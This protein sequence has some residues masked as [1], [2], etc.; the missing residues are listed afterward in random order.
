MNDRYRCV[1]LMAVVGA[2]LL[3]GVTADG[4]G[5][6]VEWAG[7]GEH[8]FFLR[9]EPREIGPRTYDEMPAQ[10]EIDF[11]ALLRGITGRIDPASLQVIRFDARTGK[12]IRSNNAFSTGPYDQPF[13]WY[14][15]AIPYDFPEFAQALD[16]T[17]GTIE[18]QVIER[19]GYYYGAVGN[20]ERGRLA[21]THT[22]EG[23]RSSDYAVYFSLLPE[24]KAPGQL[25][26]RGWLGD[27][28]QRTEPYGS[29]TTGAG[30][31]RIAVA[32]W[33]ND[34]LTDILYGEDYGHLFWMPNT[35]RRD[36]PE[37]SHSRMITDGSDVPV[38]AGV[39]LAPLIVDWNGDGLKD[40]LA[41]THW[42]RVAF[43]KNVGTLEHPRLVYRGLLKADNAIFTLPFRPI[44]GRSPDPFKTDY[45]PVLEAA[46]W[47]GDGQV[48][49]LA[50]GYVTGR[51]F[52]FR[53]VGR[54]SD[55]LPSLEFQGPLEA[56][57]APLNVGD[58]CAAPTAADFDGDGDLDLMS[59]SLAMTIGEDLVDRRKRNFLRYYENVGT[60][61][62]AILKEVDFPRQG[63]FPSGGLATPRAVDLNGDGL[64]DLA[65]SSRSDIYIYSNIGSS[66]QPRFAVH[67]RPLRVRWGRADLPGTG[68]ETPTQFL[69][70]NADGH[71]DIVSA[72]QVWINDG[73]GSPGTYRAPVFVVPP[74]QRI[75]HTSGTGDGWFW[76]RL[77][78][79]DK[80][81][82]F[83]VLFG[84]FS[85]RIWFHRNRG[86]A[87][88]PQIDTQ[89]Y[90][91]Q[92]V[93]GQEIRVGPAGLDPTKSFYALQGARTVFAMADMDQDG[94]NDIVVGDTFGTV[95]YYENVGSS[96][97]PV[98]A[99]AHPVGDL[100]S[101]LLVDAADW[102]GDGKID[103]LAGSSSGEVRVFLNVGKTD[104]ARFAEGFDPKL[105]RIIQ[106]RVMAVDL[107]DDGDLDVFLPSTQGSCFVERSFVEHGYAPGTLLG[108][109][110]T[111]RLTQRGDR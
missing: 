79:L 39:G 17:K 4:A 40:L 62:K 86:T 89:G 67:D 58:W 37:F 36:R 100:K 96:E 41:G 107:N 70:W 8:R 105:P 80:D 91:L 29:T 71:L 102:N 108:S 35:G 99:A 73:Q 52:F 77:Y 55:G 47:D 76:P 23:N 5:P 56:D 1:G 12:P 109:L 10:V 2:L 14:D 3:T 25:A 85:G 50:G 53:N 32:D 97:K 110:E 69:D 42:N 26:P 63:E 83:D 9:V 87:E 28:M 19:A 15:A 13:R 60:R 51:I 72:Y 34:G 88:E 7:T 68:A 54:G 20:L 75:T 57:G 98:F 90:P 49:L 84:D 103:I 93:D 95:R 11:A 44:V 31:S 81:G 18:R 65:V 22:Q 45:Y 94:L 59:G 64:L 43:F 78:D 106:P 66:T 101:R 21:W 27:G 48:D 82:R 30:H 46:D 104:A 92:T 38:D 111:L 74:N 33:N 6:P 61:T 16:R 24:G